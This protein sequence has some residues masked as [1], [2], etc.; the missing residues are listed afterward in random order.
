MSATETEAK[1]TVRSKLPLIIGA[2]LVVVLTSVGVVGFMLLRGSGEEEPDTEA[3]PG[4]VVP[5][6]DEMT[7]NLA[8]GRFLKLQLALQLTEEATE[9]AGES[10]AESLDGS[11][12]QDAAISVFSQ[13]KYNDLLDETKK[14]EARTKLT[15]AANERYDGAVL[16]VYF[17]QFV[18]Q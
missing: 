1:T 2:A 16:Q 5:L 4:V 14:E 17:R 6:E 8:D 13:Y 9:A 18:M 10:P 11:M 3:K 7:L 12:A 15:A